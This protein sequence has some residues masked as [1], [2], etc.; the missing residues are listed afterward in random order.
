MVKPVDSENGSANL[1]QVKL[2]LYLIRDLFYD[3]LQVQYHLKCNESTLE[4][5][6]TLSPTDKRTDRS[7]GFHY[8]NEI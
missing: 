2:R 6:L 5:C 4:K 8:E 7:V 1:K 3:E